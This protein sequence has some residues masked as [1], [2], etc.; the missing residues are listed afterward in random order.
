MEGIVISVV[1]ELRTR[2]L[3]FKFRLPDDDCKFNYEYM[4]ISCLEDSSIVWLNDDD[5]ADDD[6]NDNGDGDDG[7]DYDDGDD[8]D[9]N[10]ALHQSLSMSSSA[11]MSMSM[12]I[13]P[14]RCRAAHSYHT[15]YAP[16][17]SMFDDTVPEGKR[18]GGRVASCNR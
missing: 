18:R 5:E 10:T 1:R 15:E 7:D 8:G 16:S 13:K 4:W 9:N 6:N 2:E 17:R 14:I 11:S 12:S 3:C